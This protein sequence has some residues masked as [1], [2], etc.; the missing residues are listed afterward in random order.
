MY[1]Y[2]CARS[3]KRGNF[4][5]TFTS[6]SFRVQLVILKL[7]RT[8]THNNIMLLA[9]K[10]MF[11]SKL[12]LNK[13]WGIKIKKQDLNWKYLFSFFALHDRKKCYKYNKKHCII[14][15]IKRK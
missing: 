3:D 5:F 4:F 13:Q 9:L 10:W 2:N 7:A 14:I 15:W 1:S 6:V 12:M 8:Y 11:P